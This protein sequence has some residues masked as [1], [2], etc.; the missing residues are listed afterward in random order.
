[1]RFPSLVPS[2]SKDK[3][4]P[5][6][7][8]QQDIR[9]APSTPL[10]VAPP[11]SHVSSM[12]ITLYNVIRSAHPLIPLVAMAVVDLTRFVGI[13]NVLRVVM[14]VVAFSHLKSLG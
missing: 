2:C 12:R 8:V 13:T 9:V 14:K 11:E 7:S 5:A 6:R 1:V 10:S 4:V 3:S